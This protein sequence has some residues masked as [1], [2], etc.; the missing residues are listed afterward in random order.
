MKTKSGK[1]KAV[2]KA[3]TAVAQESATVPVQIANPDV[4]RK[5]DLAC[6]QSPRE[7]FEGVDIWPGA[8]HVVDLQQYPWPFKDNSVLEIASS[9]YLEHVPMYPLRA[10]PDGSTQDQLFAFFDECYRIL[11]PDGWAT[12]IVPNARS[13]GAFQDPTHRRFIVAETFL[14]LAK[15]WREMNKLDHYNVK[16]DFGI[17]VQPIIPA[18]YGT[19]H[20]EVQQKRF[21]HEWNT[22]ISWQARL[23]ALKPAV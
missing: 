19:W 5:L 7:G 21:N 15:Q 9:H 23:K 12:I 20:A 2:L 14:Y 18:E 1:S 16:C 11:V 8:K 3:H 10:L 4:T 22:V 13:N 17:D 6:G